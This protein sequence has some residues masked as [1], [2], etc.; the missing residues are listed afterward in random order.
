MTAQYLIT[1]ICDLIQIQSR[2]SLIMIAIK[3]H[4]NKYI[5]ILIF[6]IKVLRKIQQSPDCRCNVRPSITLLK[7]LHLSNPHMFHYLIAGAKSVHQSSYWRCYING[8]DHNWCI[9]TWL[10]VHTLP[11][12]KLWTNSKFWIFF[13]SI[14]MSKKINIFCP[15]VDNTIFNV[16]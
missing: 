6:V 13:M 5:I 8:K 11:S 14:F 7:V 12:V 15:Y 1:K 9:F 10:Q 3:M 4:W 16:Y 2:S